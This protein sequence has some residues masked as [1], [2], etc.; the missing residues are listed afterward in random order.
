MAVSVLISTP[1]IIQQH[2]MQICI[3]FYPDLVDKYGKFEWKLIS[4]VS[5][6]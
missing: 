3:E 4:A 2:C 6:V 5:D 1:T